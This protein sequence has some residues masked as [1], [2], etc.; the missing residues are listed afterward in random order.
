MF[1]AQLCQT[2]LSF[3][4]LPADNDEALLFGFA[5]SLQA[6]AFR[7]RLPTKASGAV[8]SYHYLDDLVSPRLMQYSPNI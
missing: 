4:K 2:E 5:Q 7:R 3:L 6:Y 8:Q 1:R